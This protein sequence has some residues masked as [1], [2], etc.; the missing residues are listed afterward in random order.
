[1]TF[2]VRCDVTNL[3][4]RGADLGGLFAQNRNLFRPS[5]YRMLFD[6]MSFNRDSNNILDAGEAAGTVAEYFS[7]NQ[8]STQFYEKYFLPLGSAIWSC[9]KNILE[10]F[11]IH[12][13]VR[14]Y[15]HHGLLSLKD[16]PQWRVLCH[17]SRRLAPF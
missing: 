5:Y 17:G 1:M 7:R 15:R 2:S 8:Y 3:E 16:R 11:P 12:F 4:Y 13:I 6:I 14:F 9:P 10:N